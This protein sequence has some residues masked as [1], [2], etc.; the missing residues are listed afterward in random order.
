MQRHFSNRGEPLAE[1]AAAKMMA[2]RGP[3][4][5]SLLPNQRGGGV[6]RGGWKARVPEAIRPSSSPKVREPQD[7]GRS[8]V[9]QPEL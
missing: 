7:E 6:T 5:K 3:L 1:V 8:V 2:H 4:A 9:S